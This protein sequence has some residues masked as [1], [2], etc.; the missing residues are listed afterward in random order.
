MEV[1]DL[2]NNRQIRRDS[3]QTLSSQLEEI[4]HE[5]IENGV[6]TPGAAIPSER[7]LSKI[8][9]LSRMTVR[10]ALDRLVAAG[11]LYRVDG[12]GTF[13]SEPKVR[14]K[15]LSLSG[16]REQT[17]HLGY[18]PSA[19]LLGI[20]RTIVP[21]K[22]AK[23]L[24]VPPDTLVYLIERVVFGNNVPLAL[25]RSYIPVALCPTLP[26]QDLANI[27]LY[28]LL[29]NQ[30]GIQIDHASET[31][32]TTLAS[33]RESLLLGIE[34]GAPLFLLRITMFDDQGTPIEYVKVIFRGDRVQL[35][36]DI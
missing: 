29:R 1:Q 25:H 22:I 19:K 6:W 11:L 35:S 31:L 16:L 33:T 32:E 24:N 15:A 7:E 30:Y 2:L 14:F 10:K 20:E 13:V 17:I 21:E 8:Y 36:L 34:P 3:D 27:S 4:I 5:G 23:V 28:S 26:E 9:R 18:S 12:K